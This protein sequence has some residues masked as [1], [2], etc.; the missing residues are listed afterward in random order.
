MRDGLT[1]PSDIQLSRGLPAL[2]G[3]EQRKPIL[4][5][6]YSTVKVFRL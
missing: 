3:I 4:P 2:I 1:L 6:A 5:C